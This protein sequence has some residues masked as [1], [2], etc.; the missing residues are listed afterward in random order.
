MVQ[1]VHRR[2]DRPG[3]L[4]GRLGRPRRVRAA[5]ASRIAAWTLDTGMGWVHTTL[6]VVGVVDPTGLAD[7]TN[8]MLYLAEGDY[9]NFG[10]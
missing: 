7:I 4:G 8:G 1:P 3:P 10:V 6:N 2:D 9:K 5:A